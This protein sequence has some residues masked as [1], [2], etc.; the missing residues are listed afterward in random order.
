M[1]DE[2]RDLLVGVLTRKRDLNIL[3]NEG[4]YRIPVSASE[5]KSVWPPKWLAFYESASIRRDY[6]I[7]RFAPVLHIE[8]RT[9]EE[10]FP[11]EPAGAR[12]GKRYY[13]VAIGPIQERAIRFVR[14]RHFA[15]IRTSMK[16]F[17]RAETVNDL[18]ADSPL[19]DRLWGEFKK[20]RIPAE[21]QWEEM[22]EGS[23]YYLDFALFCNAGKIDV[24]AD[25]ESY[26]ITKEQAPRDNERN[27]ELTT[28]GWRVLRF[29]GA[30]IVNQLAE[31]IDQVYR[32]VEQ[33]KG[34]ETSKLVP[35]RYIGKRGRVVRQPS[36][37]EER[38]E[39]DPPGLD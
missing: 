7:Y 36:L 10:L 20:L 34:F 15:F 13:K 29:D 18:F 26:H 5:P 38:S 25:G 16:R 14:P 8:E 30:K 35:D 2:L 24:E 22:V 23:R 37:F 21:R 12:A 9:R 1:T 19:E 3:L 4:W 39:Y 6:G 27:N 28:K 11:G 33:L 32:T 31:C 17:E